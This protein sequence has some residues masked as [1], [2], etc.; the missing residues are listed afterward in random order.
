MLRP[1]LDL[2]RHVVL[3][4]AEI[5]EAD[6]G[7]LE[8]MQPRQGGVH[9][10]VDFCALGGIRLRHV[11]FPKNAA[12]GVAHDVERRADD[13]GVVAIENRLGDREA[14]RIERGDGAVFAVDRVRGGE[15]LAGRLAA[16]HVAPRRRLQQI[17]RVRLAAAELLHPER[18][19]KS[20]HPGGEIRLEPRRV[21]A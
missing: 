14:L 15:Q 11:R 17:G 12:L 5:P 16:Q 8:R 4:L 1:A 21:E 7:R 2:A 18:P 20:R 19:G 9:R 10:V 3:A 13:V 6:L